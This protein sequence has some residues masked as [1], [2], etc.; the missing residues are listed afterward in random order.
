MVQTPIDLVRGLNRVSDTDIK[1]VSK[2]LANLHKTLLDIDNKVSGLHQEARRAGSASGYLKCLNKSRLLLKVVTELQKEFRISSEE[3]IRLSS[4]EEKS[5]N[6]SQ[7][8]NNQNYNYSRIDLKNI[9]VRR[10]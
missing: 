4:D 2:E 6:N 1:S 5:S 8:K 9:P 3:L 10:R 7:A